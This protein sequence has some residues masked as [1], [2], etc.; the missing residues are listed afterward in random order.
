VARVLELLEQLDLGR[1]LGRLEAECGAEQRA[2]LAAAAQGWL[3]RS[4]R[5][6]VWQGLKNEP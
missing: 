3:S 1:A 5:L 2:T 6:G 4:V